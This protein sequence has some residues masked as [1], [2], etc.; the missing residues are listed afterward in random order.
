MSYRCELI[1]INVA[2]LSGK[3][4]KNIVWRLEKGRG[5]LIPGKNKKKGERRE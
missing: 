4:G 3:R 5:N 1:E 2:G